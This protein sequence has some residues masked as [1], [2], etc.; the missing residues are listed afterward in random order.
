MILFSILILI[1]HS[2]LP[3]LP[4][5]FLFIFPQLICSRLLPLFSFLLL[6]TLFHY[7]S[8]LF[9]LI[10]LFSSHFISSLFFS[11]SL[12]LSPP[13]ISSHVFS[14]HLVSSLSKPLDNKST[15]SGHI[16]RNA[17]LGLLTIDAVMPYT[18]IKKVKLVKWENSQE[19]IEKIDY[20]KNLNGN[21]KGSQD[22]IENTISKIKQDPRSRSRFRKLTSI[23]E[24]NENSN[25]DN[26]NKIETNIDR[27]MNK[28]TNNDRKKFIS[29]KLKQK[30][31]QK[32][33]KS[34]VFNKNE[35]YSEITVEWYVG[36]CVNVDATWLSIHSPPLSYLSAIITPPTTSSTSTSSSL[37]SGSNWSAFLEEIDTPTFVPLAP[38]S[39]DETNK[40]EKK[41]REKLRKKLRKLY[42][43][44]LDQKLEKDKLSNDLAGLGGE[45]RLKDA[46]DTS[47]KDMAE[48][49]SRS[50]ISNT[51]ISNTK[52]NKNLSGIQKINS[53]ETL[54]LTSSATIQNVHA[55]DDI[56]DKK[57]VFPLPVSYAQRGLGRWGQGQNP[58]NPQ[59]FSAVVRLSVSTDN[60][61]NRSSYDNNENNS[62]NNNDNNN[63][64]NNDDNS[65]SNLLYINDII[66]L[67]PGIYY[68]IAW[69]KVDP[70]WGT[71]NQG[72]GSKNPES[73]LANGRTNTEWISKQPESEYKKKFAKKKTSFFSFGNTTAYNNNNNNNNNNEKISSGKEEYDRMR[74]R[75]VSGRVHWPS[76]PIIILIK[77]NGDVALLSEVLGC[78]W[79][80]RK[81]ENNYDESSI[82]WNIT[83]RNNQTI[84]ND[85]RT[86]A[87]D[88]ISKSNNNNN[89]SSTNI[90]N[91]TNN[92]TN[93]NNN[94]NNDNNNENKQEDK[95]EYNKDLLQ[96]TNNLFP[97]PSDSIDQKITVIDSE[98]SNDADTS[99]NLNGYYSNTLHFKYR[100]SFVL[101]FIVFLFGLIIFSIRNFRQYFLYF[102][103]SPRGDDLMYSRVRQI[104]ARN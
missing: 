49:S 3:S 35:K 1:L 92:T 71:K 64:N 77:K 24:S 78:A 47:M 96:R 66:H 39:K 68:L 9:F 65:N 90:K 60:N 50:S 80:D 51:S 56:K 72:Y 82:S 98:Q 81:I 23:K 16:S 46:A 45:I 12:L 87:N 95:D 75:I 38:I 76:D 22:E 61:N 27:N 99:L 25:N 29:R 21:S 97:T 14:T 18:C 102:S 94:N 88:D 55:R 33:L 103:T 31:H 8:P 48:S 28:E 62:S 34:E 79:W 84:K 36:G 5:S 59:M 37:L 15:E 69:S 40:E 74:G 43:N 67:D 4:V 17:R 85:S 32:S 101:F 63:N 58:K 104:N 91:N 41:E 54:T 44:D 6:S 42:G 93:T 86:N 57:F 20:E 7:A 10:L 11:F 2:P 30:F 100:K 89:N 70:S 19:I 52:K 26:G 53:T 83:N 73:Y 13:L